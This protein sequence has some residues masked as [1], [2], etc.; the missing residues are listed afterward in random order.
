[1][2]AADSF[3]EDIESLKS[4]LR[5][6]DAELA[7]ARAK[8]SCLL[9]MILFE[10]YGQHQPLNRHSTR[11]AHEGVELSLSMLADQVGGCALLLHPLYDLI[12]D[13][14]FAGV[15]RAWGRHDRAGAGQGQDADRATMDLRAFASAARR[16]GCMWVITRGIIES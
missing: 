10:K 6:R 16:G 15:P 1:M 7:Q 11:Y 13:H 9:A 14:V 12:R 3:P 5:E 2:S 8:A 4:L